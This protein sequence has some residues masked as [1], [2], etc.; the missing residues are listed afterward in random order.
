MMRIVHMLFSLSGFGQKTIMRYDESKQIYLT[1]V[2]DSV[3]RGV[4]F[5]EL[6][7]V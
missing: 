6:R 7:L 4:I 2:I 3:C 1:F 5:I